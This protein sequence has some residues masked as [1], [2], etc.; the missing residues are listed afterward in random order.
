MSNE[1]KPL[2]A[3]TSGINVPLEIKKFFVK[4]DK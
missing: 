3:A 4:K 2:K 1:K